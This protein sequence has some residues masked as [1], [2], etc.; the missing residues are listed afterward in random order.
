MDELKP[1]PFCGSVAE[2]IEIDADE[3]GNDGLYAVRCENSDCYAYKCHMN[4]DYCY[5]GCCL[6]DDRDECVAAWNRRPGTKDRW[7]N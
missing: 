7:D 6:F 2:L 1:C 4:V 3:C 5:G